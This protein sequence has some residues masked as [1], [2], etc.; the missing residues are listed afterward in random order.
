MK[1]Y[2]TLVSFGQ[3]DIFARYLDEMFASAAS[4]FFYGRAEFVELTS[5]PGWPKIVRD[6]L[7]HI[8][9]SRRE[10]RGQFVF[11]LDADLLLEGPVD[12][13]IVGDGITATLHPVQNALPPDEMTYERD[14][15]S[16]A[17]V[18]YGEGS[19]YYVGGILGGTRSEFFDL[20][21]EIDAMCAADGDFTPVWQD[22]SYL[23]R[24]LLDQPPAVELDERYCAWWNHQVPDARI[25][26]LNK[27]PDEIRWRDSQTAEAVAT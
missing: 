8:L 13:E 21:R 1:P 17:Y 14:P 6:R 23:N 10:V 5:T 18:P 4:R 27:T 25:R 12:D 16:A 24:I 9:A 20:C 3:G 26:A 22:E 19:R 15:R 11:L 2:A 7:S